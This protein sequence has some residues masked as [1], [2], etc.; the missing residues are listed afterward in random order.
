MAVTT[1]NVVFC[2]IRTQFLPYSR[3]ITSRYSVQLVNAT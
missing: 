2:D 1:K 3:H